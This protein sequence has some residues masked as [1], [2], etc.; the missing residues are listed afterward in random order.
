MR[1][2]APIRVVVVDDSATVRAVLRRL[3]GKTGDLVVVAE[4]EDGAHAV[5]A[6]VELAPDVVLMDIEMP[7]MDGFEAT[8]RI[9]A[10]RPTPIVVLTSRANRD[11]VATAFE[12]IRRGAVE[13]FAKPADTAGWDELSVTLPPAVRAAAGARAASAV[14]ARARPTPPLHATRVASTG[15]QQPRAP[16]RFVA[17]GASTGGPNAIHEFLKA[18]PA[19]APAPVLIVQHIAAGFEEGFAD[20]LAKDLKR[21]VRIAGDGEVCRSG[22]VRVAPAGAHLLLEPRGVLRLDAARPPRGGHRPSADELFLSCAA[23]CPRE[24][25]GV[26]L[27]GMG[28]DGAEGL[29]ALRRAGG[30]TMVQDEASS[31]VFGMPR[32]ALE[33]GAADLALP[34]RELA[35]AIARHWQEA[36]P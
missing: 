5:E 16:I 34:P 3:L 13:V 22:T 14:A 29:L 7:A 33:R 12:A 31:V 21:D 10:V 26:L 36:R 6:T 27:S 11:Q 25:A 23:S 1:A 28:A 15:Q 8:A 9:M 20:W 24:V 2:A 18:L 32:A 4:A 35:A 17:I 19:A 30:L